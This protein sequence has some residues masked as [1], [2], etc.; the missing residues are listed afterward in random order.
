MDR[1]D[2]LDRAALMVKHRFDDMR[3]DTSPAMPLAAVR[4]KSWNVQRSGLSASSE[5]SMSNESCIDAP[6]V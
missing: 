3:G 6:A 2:A 4:R 5:A 1:R